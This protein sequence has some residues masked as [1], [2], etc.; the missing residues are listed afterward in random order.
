MNQNSSVRILFLG[1]I[2][3]KPGRALILS[4]LPEIRERFH[5]DL[6]LA[7]G[8]NAASDKGSGITAAI[9]HELHAAGILAI[10]LGNHTWGQKEFLNEI[11]SVPF[12]CRPAN[13]A[14]SAPGA[15]WVELPFCGK[16]LGVACFL[17]QASMRI[18]TDSSP[19]RAASELLEQ[20]P[21]ID[22]W[23][24]DFHAET[25]AEKI[26]MGWHLNGR[27]LAVMG[28]NTHVQSNDAQVLDG[29]TAYMTDL[30]M[31]GPH[32]SIIGHKIEARLPSFLQSLPPRAEVA[33]E[34]VQLRGCLIEADPINLKAQSA[35]AFRW[36]L[37]E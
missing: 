6:I 23:I 13:F 26:A 30:G 1:D 14:A 11:D 33:S 17:G 27:V 10:T 12:V 36:P 22:S 18:L 7:N 25:T 19:F 21:E 2:V 3:G 8:E 9:A 28:T 32:R 15:S 4:Q 24:F 5:L 16:R 29:G 20:H 37:P 31:C 34:D 35:K